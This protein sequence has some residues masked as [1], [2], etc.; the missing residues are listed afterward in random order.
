MASNFEHSETGNWNISADYVE[1]LMRLFREAEA[2]NEIARYGFSDMLLD[3][4]TAEKDKTLLRKRGF[5]KYIYKLK[6]IISW[7]KLAIK[8][9]KEKEDFMNFYNTLEF[10][11]ENTL[12]NIIK[13]EKSGMKEKE[14]IDEELFNINFKKVEDIDRELREPMNKY[15]LIFMQKETF[16][17]KEFKKKM[18]ESFVGEG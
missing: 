5:E 16:D 10:I 13:I 12:K 2:Y 4:S 1:Q 7:S 6:R 17:A 8:T 9:K 14:V 11:E 15:D 3:L 18:K